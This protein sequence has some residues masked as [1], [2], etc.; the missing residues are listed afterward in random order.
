MNR[1]VKE[2]GINRQFA[3]G[4][5]MIELLVVAAIIA[6]LAAML[7]PALQKTQ[8]A[9]KR[10]KCA[11]NLK[12]IGMA[13]IL[14]S[15]DNQGAFPPYT[16]AP[17]PGEQANRSLWPYL[18]HKAAPKKG[19]VFH[20]PSSVGKPPVTWDSDPVRDLGGAYYTTEYSTYGFNAHLRGV[21]PPDYTNF[22]Q[23]TAPG[24]VIWS[25]DATSHRIDRSFYGFIPA[26]RHGGRGWDGTTSL[27]NKDR[28]EGFN[29]VFVDGHV[30]WIPWPKF[31]AWA[32]AGWPSKRPY[33]WF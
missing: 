30:E 8:E 2:F 10:S 12:Q 19:S 31:R 27:S 22:K 18:G 32:A 20:C 4:F 25:T 23:V 24:Y 28:G 1:D 21:M 6:I 16:M 9:G 5:T 17:V 14:Y 15:D 13:T 26:F 3:R 7:L 33:A 29:A 11:N